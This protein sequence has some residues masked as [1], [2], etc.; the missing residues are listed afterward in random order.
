MP[1]L[2]LYTLDGMVRD[3]EPLKV[4]NLL[5]F[6]ALSH[7]RRNV[8]LKFRSREENNS[9]FELLFRVGAAVGRPVLRLSYRRDNGG[10]SG[11]V[12]GKV[13]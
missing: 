12:T 11:V 5:Y 8:K 4:S 10:I 3:A 13:K 1:P 2:P 9:K 6:F 7:L